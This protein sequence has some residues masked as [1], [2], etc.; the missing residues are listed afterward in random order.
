VPAFACA[1]TAA[2]A[3]L[4]GATPV[5]VDVDDTLTICPQALQEAINQTKKGRLRPAGIVAVDLFGLPAD[6]ER[7]E[8]IA[9]QEGLWVLED[10]AQSLGAARFDKQAGAF[11]RMSVLSFS[12]EAPLSCCGKGGAVCTT[13]PARR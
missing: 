11:G 12:R 8:K 1:A 13:H 3:A 7:I 4:R 10:A 2:A 6:Y 5:F 9:Q